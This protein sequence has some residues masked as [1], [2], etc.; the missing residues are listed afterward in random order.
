MRIHKA[1]RFLKDISILL[2]FV[3][4]G[5][6]SGNEQTDNQLEQT[7]PFLSIDFSGILKQK[8]EV[9]VS[10]IANKVDYILLEKTP[11]SLI[12]S[13]MDAS[14]TSDYIFIRH[15]GSP[16]L[17][18]FSRDGK[19]VRQIGSIGRGP[20][21]YG[22]MRKFSI[23]EKRELIYIHSN[24]TQRILVYSFKGE[25]VKT[26]K[27]D[28]SGRGIISWSRDSL[29]VSFGEPHMGN[30]SFVFIETNTHGDTIQGIKNHIFWNSNESSHF[31]I[32]YWG[33]NSF[34]RANDKLHMKGW[35][36]DTV[37]TYNKENKIV[38]EYFI[39]LKNHKI[40]EDKIPER[41]SV[42][43]IPGNCYWTGVNESSD[44]IF[45][46]YGSVWSPKS[47]DKKEEQGYMFV[48]KNTGKGIALANNGDEYGFINDLDAGPDF[49]PEYS[50]DSL[51]YFFI[52]AIDFKEYLDSDKFRNKP[53]KYPD[54]KERL[55]KLN[56]T[57]EE[58]DNHILIMAHLK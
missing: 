33:R 49:K 37:Y 22:L 38:P 42:K 4:S 50:N 29:F 16:L 2:I 5:C 13:I 23:D 1:S 43:P 32:S 35:Y 53:A 39:N 21:E 3:L 20:K 27:F 26:I 31:M 54:K 36:N 57:L 52:P 44:Y 9:P 7:R 47:N 28:G 17:T 40:P 41:N 11:K 8:R 19:F 10:M 55:R 56:K 12:G 30:E 45:I 48:N 6:H 18:Q 58:N 25:Y 15:N 14:I 24:W 46:R 51:A 34:Y